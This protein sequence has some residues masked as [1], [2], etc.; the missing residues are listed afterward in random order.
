M[1]L[2][3]CLWYCT[4]KSMPKLPEIVSHLDTNIQGWD[5]HFNLDH[6]NWL[7]VYHSF[8]VFF[9]FWIISP[10]FRER[11]LGSRVLEGRDELWRVKP[12]RILESLCG[13]PE[14][15]GQGRSKKG[16]LIKRDKQIDNIHFTFRRIIWMCCFSMSRSSG[17]PSWSST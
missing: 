16:K 12:V 11:A 4:W 8:P 13:N 2:T 14:I 17:F 10:D 5:S 3:Y 6:S 15:C 7:K 9:G 1:W